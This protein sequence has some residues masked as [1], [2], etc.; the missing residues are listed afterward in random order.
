MSIIVSIVY[1]CLTFTHLSGV[2]VLQQQH[3][4]ALLPSTVT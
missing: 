2:Q 1:Y 3:E 4:F